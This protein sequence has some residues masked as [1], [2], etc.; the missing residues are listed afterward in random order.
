[1]AVYVVAGVLVAALAT[2]LISIGSEEEP[3]Q[4]IAGGY[5][6]APGGTSC[7]GEKFDVKQSGRFV[8]LDNS[9]QTLSGKLKL[10][11]A[12]LTGS[13][14]CVR[15]GS[16]SLDSRVR[17]GS[18]TG[19]VGDA[20]L[21]ATLE[22]DAAPA[23][24]TRKLIPESVT[25]EYSLAPRSDCLGGS[26]AIE[27]EGD[28]LKLLAGEREAG[29]ARYSDGALTGTVECEDGESEITGEALDRTINLTVGEDERI[30][31]TKRREA[32]SLFASF[33]LAI[34]VVMLVARL[35]GM[36][37]VKLG[38][39]RVMGEV[40]AGI[41]LGPTI[42]GAIAPEL[43]AALFP[44]DVI[45]YLGVVAQLGLVF[46]MFL[47]G[48]EI[49]P[50]QLKGRL[51]QV[52]AISNASVALPMLLGIAVALPIYEAVGPDTKF[53]GFALFMGVSMS[54]TAFPVLARILVERRMLKRP[55][56]AIALAS[57]A[58]DDVTAWF[59]IALATAV[60]VAGS[61][62][63]VLRVIALAIVFVL[64]MG[65]LVRP[66][67]GRVSAAYDEAGRVPGGWVALIFA[68][69]LLSAFATEEIG[70]ALIF[71]A[72]VM[73]L[74]MPR[75]AGLTEDVTRRVEDFVVTLLLPLF[76]AY[77]G[78]RT[79]IGL[80]DRPEL[81]LMTLALLLVAIVGKFG[82]RR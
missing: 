30:T 32:G 72:F 63:D 55:V 26:L 61:S 39:P 13:V 29:E 57:A 67:L 70:I 65:L 14:N 22:R 41:T 79:N 7:L 46:Y 47:V 2:F 80:L 75:H 10:D 24:S 42:L 64:V 6:V 33:F 40:I 73:G 36:A 17:D 5:D 25:G 58:I 9:D 48:L 71:G 27:E 53:A 31:A 44:S 59:L 16:Q 82:R 20:P 76:F 50:E 37:S 68:G 4:P 34:A 56:G 60:A 43:Q 74:I 69:V 78:L 15:G 3:Q 62:S 54:V 12:E 21:E 28:G 45:P 52:A 51:G 19:R 18:I 81:W 23:G 35:F 8:N 49:D 77:T 11:G 38:Q 1:M 66:V